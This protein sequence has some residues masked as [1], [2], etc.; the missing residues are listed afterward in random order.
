MIS[1]SF[2]AAAALPLSFTVTVPAGPERD[3]IVE[4][5]LPAGTEIPLGKWPDVACD[6]TAC[7]SQFTPGE[8]PGLAL[9][10]KAGREERTHR[11]ELRGW[12]SPDETPAMRHTTDDAT[13]TLLAGGAKIA[14]Y[15]HAEDP[16]PQGADPKF[17]RSAF[18]YP[19]WSPSGAELAMKRPSD[20]YHHMGLWHAW[21]ET[22]FEGQPVDFWNLAK[23]LGTVRF[24]GY[25]WKA[26]GPLW[27]G[28]Q[29]KQEH[30]ALKTTSGARTV[31]AETFTLRAWKTV[32]G[33]VLDYDCVQKNVTD[34]PLDLPAYRYG[35]GLAYRAPASWLKANSDYLTDLGKTRTDGHQSRARW[36]AMSGPTPGGTGQVAILSHGGNHDAPQRIR[37]WNDDKQG[38]IFFNYVPVQEKP[39]S[40]PPGGTV[41]FRYRVLLAD[42][43]PDAA[44]LDALWSDYSTPP[45]VEWK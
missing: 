26:A 30:V 13:T 33:H 44:L 23:G 31:L 45:K 24:A 19:L 38:R 2:L 22:R 41:T 12:R 14:S 18:V 36:V 28:V 40:I 5:A 37:V 15:H 34:S 1:L 32:A 27:C 11:F 10:V 17:V 29:A 39:W 8:V 20:H 25:E 21:T 7:P 3:V 43:K 4:T 16:A 42:A 9:V 35:G 6:G